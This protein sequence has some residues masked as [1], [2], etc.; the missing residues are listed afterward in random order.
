MKPD[1]RTAIIYDKGAGFWN[2]DYWKRFRSVGGVYSLLQ[3]WRKNPVELITV[4]DPA[5]PGT[6]SRKLNLDELKRYRTLIVPGLDHVTKEDLETLRA[7]VEAGNGLLLMGSIGSEKK[8]D[9]TSIAEDAY[10]ILGISTPSGP[11]PSGFVLKKEKH[12]A[13]TAVEGTGSFGSFRISPDK[14]DAASYK[15]R[16]DDTWSVM[17]EEVTDSGKRA[18]VLEK[19]I[20][21]GKIGY[22]NSSEAKAFTGQMN[23]LFANFATYV[24]STSQLIMPVGMSPASSLNAFKSEDGLTRYFHILTPDGESNI[25]IRLY[26]DKG[27]FPTSAEM[28]QS[29]GSIIPLRMDV[30]AATGNAVIKVDSIKP[31][32]AII[33]VKTEKR[34]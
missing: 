16:Y 19:R 26:A 6:S 17:A 13:F 27:Y 15:P 18:C 12:P 28:M 3:C 29:D 1:A 5:E 23:Q 31:T 8:L 11:E 2:G 24:S 14:N 10:R 20:G 25:E 22:I 34:S 30:A 33:R 21:R 4:G 32:W 9:G 7:Y